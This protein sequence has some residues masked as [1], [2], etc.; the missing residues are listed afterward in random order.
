MHN[1][2]F[3]AWDKKNKRM[4]YAGSLS[5]VGDFYMAQHK[6]DINFYERF[7]IDYEWTRSTGIESYNRKTI[8]ENDI[9]KDD[10]N[11]YV[12]RFGNYKANNNR[13][14]NNEVAYGFYIESLS[15]K[16]VID[17][18]TRIEYYE[19]IG[20]IYENPEFLEDK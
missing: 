8:F 14:Y 17:H 18:A 3:R 11:I 1:L 16:G 5:G 6:D 10:T 20:N 15:H 7:L 4:F 19:V 12:V 9:V 2:A 13:I